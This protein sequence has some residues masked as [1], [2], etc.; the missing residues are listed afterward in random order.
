MIIQE[1]ITNDLDINLDIIIEYFETL[2]D[3]E[4][5]TIEGL[6]QHVD[7]YYICS[8]FEINSNEEYQGDN[9]ELIELFN[10]YND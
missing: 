7:N 4:I 6:M 2:E 8:D 1:I 9:T 5:P 3:G 10:E